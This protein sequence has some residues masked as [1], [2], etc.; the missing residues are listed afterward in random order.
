MFDSLKPASPASEDEADEDESADVDLSDP[1]QRQFV[2]LVVVFNLAVLAAA[3]G[4]L[5]LYFR[6]RLVLGGGLA[7]V[8]F[9]GLAYGLYTYRGVQRAIDAGVHDDADD[10]DDDAAE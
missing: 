9:A 10:A 2:Y 5:F 8:G 1:L 7:I 4:L 6:G 3:L